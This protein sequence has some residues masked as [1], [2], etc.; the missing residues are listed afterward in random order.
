MIYLYIILAL[1]IAGL[2][3]MSFEAGF[4][5]V[6]RIKH[7]N[8]KQSLKIVQLSDIHIKY[9]R[10]SIHKTNNIIL[11]ENPDVILITGDYL[12][13][14]SDVDKFMSWLDQLVLK[15]RVLLC[16]GNHDYKAFSGDEKGLN[17]FLKNIQD[18]GIKVLHDDCIC[19]S[20]GSVK[21]NFIGI[22]DYRSKN[23][24]ISEAL[25]KCCPDAYLKIAF[26]HNPDIVTEMPYGSVDYLFCGHYHGGQIWA[27]FDLEFKILR[28]DKLCKKGIKRGLHKVNGINLYINRGLGNVCVPFRFMSRPEITVFNLPY[29]PPH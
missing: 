26:S 12:E 6:V 9:L 2:I 11:K 25:A 28:G 24:N 15:E 19:I 29:Q 23:Y 4:V 10:V 22:K 7:S 20:K 16:L 14:T 3:Y 17:N 13:D 5:Q 18:R 8:H 1:A 21:Y 27:P